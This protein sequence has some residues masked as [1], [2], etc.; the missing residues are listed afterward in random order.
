MTA[1]LEEHVLVITSYGLWHSFK[2]SSRVASSKPSDFA[3]GSRA[4]AVAL[5]LCPPCP[6]LVFELDSMWHD[7]ISIRHLNPVL[8]TMPNQSP[9]LSACWA[10]DFN[11]ESPVQ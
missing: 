1:M 8:L 10:L 9:S 3:L 6:F 11:H 7:E 4:K 2:S 5:N